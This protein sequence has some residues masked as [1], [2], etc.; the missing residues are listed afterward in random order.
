MTLG[1]PNGC[2]EAENTMGG[3]MRLRS[4]VCGPILSSLPRTRTLKANTPFAQLQ[5]HQHDL[6]SDLRGQ[7][8]E[9]K[10]FIRGED[11][12]SNLDRYVRARSLNRIGH[13]QRCIQTAGR[14]IS[15]NSIGVAM[16][17]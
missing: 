12:V 17:R 16:D 1:G 2:I 6:E 13:S 5:S 7:L 9:R 11:L 8:P 15:P 10:R 4:D 14:Y 3:S